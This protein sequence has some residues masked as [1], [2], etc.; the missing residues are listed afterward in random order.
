MTEGTIQTVEL[1]DNGRLTS[2]L[3]IDHPEQPLVDYSYQI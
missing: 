3:A 2:Q 1:P